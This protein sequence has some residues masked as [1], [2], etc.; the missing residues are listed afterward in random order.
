[1]SSP[2]LAL[3]ETLAWKQ[4][5][6]AAILE[7]DRSHINGRIEDAREKLFLRLREITLGGNL[8]PTHGEELE[9]IHEALY[10]LDALK[11]SLA[12][13]DEKVSRAEGTSEAA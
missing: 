6:M 13:R 2:I 4:A 12:Y 5:Y 11:S 1:M 10:L 9:G 7:R 8:F 3:P